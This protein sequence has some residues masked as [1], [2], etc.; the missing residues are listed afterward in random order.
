LI[1]ILVLLHK[2]L[3]KILLFGMVRKIVVIA[4]VFE[5]LKFV[6]Q[7]VFVNLPLQLIVGYHL[8]AAFVTELLNHLKSFVVVVLLL[9][10]YQ[11]LGPVLSLLDQV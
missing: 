9:M 8:V 2:C 6:E 5:H 4:I 11:N 1:A 3:I 7:V 10:L